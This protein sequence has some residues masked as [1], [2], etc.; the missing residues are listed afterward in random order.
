[1]KKLCKDDIIVEK[2]KNKGVL[3]IGAT[4]NPYHI[5]KVRQNRLLHQKLQEVCRELIGLDVDEKSIN[6]LKHF[7]INNIFY[8]DI[9]TGKYN[10]NLK[11]KNFDFIV[12]GDIIEHLENPGLALKN[13]KKLMSNKTRIL[14]TTPNVFFYNNIQT[15]LTGKEKVHPDHTFWPSYITMRKLISSSGLKTEKFFY[16]F[17]GSYKEKSL[18]LKIIYKLI[19]NRTRY[20]LPCMFFILK[21]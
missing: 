15:F 2:C 9:L 1:M 17:W 13:I 3:H 7:G 8:G 21:K 5:E 12:F 11:N 10:V 14:L 4:D 16:C 19:L 6:E 20:L 18:K